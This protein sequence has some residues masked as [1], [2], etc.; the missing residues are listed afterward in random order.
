MPV[1]FR[2]DGY[3]VF[4]YSDEGDPR[5][6]L[7]VHVRKGG[8]EAKL[9]LRPELTVVRSYGFN[10]KELSAILGIVQRHDNEIERA[11]HEHFGD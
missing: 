11:W 5:E 6:P 7:H 1:I 9:W 2:E 8:A 10:A 3:R 4:F